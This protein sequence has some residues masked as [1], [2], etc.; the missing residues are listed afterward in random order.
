MIRDI[1][2]ALVRTSGVDAEA[3]VIQINEAPFGHNMKVA[4][5][6]CSGRRRRKKYSAC[7]SPM[8]MH[9]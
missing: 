4:R 6:S 8:S 7:Q 1:P 2:Q 3:V 9:I 5:R